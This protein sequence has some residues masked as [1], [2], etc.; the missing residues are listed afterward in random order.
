[1]RFS[2]AMAVISCVFFGL[3]ATV[4][5]DLI[6]YYDF[7]NPDPNQVVDLSSYGNDGQLVADTEA[8]E[9]ATPLSGTTKPDWIEG[10][11]G[12]GALQFCAGTDNYNSVWVPKSDSLTDLG[13][14]WAFSV[15]IRQDSRDTTPGGGA[16]YP[17]VISC[18]NYEIELGVPGWE[19]D[20]FW[21][22]NNAPWQTDIGTSYIGAGGSLGQWYHMALVYDGTDLRKYF[23]GVLVA[24]SVK[25]IPNEL[26]HDEWS[27]HG[28]I[29][30]SLKLACQ[31]WPNKDWFI[32]ALDDVAIWSYGHLDAEAVAGLYEGTYTPLTVP[33]IK[34]PVKV[35]EPQPAGSYLLNS[36]FINE[37]GHPAGLSLGLDQSRSPWTPWNWHITNNSGISTG[38]GMQNVSLWDGGE[39]NVIRYA[40]FITT[41]VQLHQEANPAAGSWQPIR[42]D[43]RYNLKARV[44]GENAVGNVIKVAFYKRSQADPNYAEPIVDPNTTA[45]TV[46]EDR[47]WQNIY[48]DYTS[49]AD[50]DLKYFQVIATI[51]QK[52]GP[53]V[54][55]TW[56][57]F[58]SI[59]ID[60]D[61]PVSCKGVKNL[62]LLNAADFDEDCQVS[63]TDLAEVAAQWQDA[64]ALE[65]RSTATE[66]LANPDFYLDV[67]RVADLGDSD[68]GSPSGWTFQPDTTEP[69]KAGIWNRADAG[70]I[71]SPGAGDYQPA[72]GSV[73]AFIDLD[74]KLVQIAETPVISGTTYYLSAMVA[75]SENS[76]QNIIRVTWDYVDDPVNPTTAVEVAVRDFV[77]PVNTVWRKLT[78]E[79]TAG[80]A[81]AGKY[82]RVTCEYLEPGEPAEEDSWALIGY[83][84]IDTAR[85]A[86]WPRVNLLTNGDF[87]EVSNLSSED[88]LKLL[89]T[90]SD[91]VAHTSGDPSGWAPGWTYGDG[92]GQGY[93]MATSNGLQCMLWAPPSQPVQGRTQELSVSPPAGFPQ[94]HLTGG[95]VSIWLE[96]NYPDMFGV[97]NHGPVS[98]IYQKVNAP[99]I[100]QGKTYYLDFT[101]CS[102][103][104]QVNDEGSLWPDNDPNF[105]VEVYWVAPGQNDL[106]GT[107]GVH[108]DS[109]AR[110][111]AFAD[112][113]MGAAGGTWQVGQVSFTADAAQ[114][115]KH[116]FVRAFGSFPYATFEEIFLSEQPRPAVGA[117]TCYELN[118]KYPDQGLASDLNGNCKID[119]G[120]LELF[121]IQWL[122]CV[123]PAGCL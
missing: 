92:K 67:D 95:R 101:A 78:A 48:A 41:E 34:E 109:I 47:K 80:A 122:D 73:A 62:G 120:D 15:W 117:Y 100:E 17:R 88:Q 79:Y 3:G 42:E 20:Y 18:A 8:G 103:W 44:A 116:F 91:W 19:Y 71:N 110:A 27:T 83:A 1:M 106:T 28:W 11:R 90:D 56:A 98:M 61:A 86:D 113:N 72:G 58:D 24:D 65:P 16:G 52:D 23:N 30:S 114:A 94:V 2:T 32:G 111:V 107:K 60:V 85:P 96:A 64:I 22:Y 51:E 59:V 29:D 77:L 75:G 31:T 119:I 93:Q 4:F 25:N 97:G 35:P 26:I 5:S 9:P 69:N 76:Y 10:V 105:T 112:D 33:F 55:E 45:I 36:T 74:T 13:G 14:R 82:L 89:A 66:L 46:T 104:G 49:G 108:W 121:A 54:G 84:S 53:G 21:P 7:E 115:G 38:Y 57:Y 118:N 87:E 63:M 50:D 43:I 12:D 70:F 81:G 123:D 102:S 6:L 39:P 99:T 40:A 37:H 68:G